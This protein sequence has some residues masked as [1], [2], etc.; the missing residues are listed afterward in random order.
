MKLWIMLCLLGLGSGLASQAM[1]LLLPAD[2]GIPFQLQDLEGRGHSSFDPDSSGPDMLEAR[3]GLAR[4]GPWL[5]GGFHLRLRPWLKAEAWVSGTGVD[6]GEHL[7]GTHT[8]RGGWTGRVTRGSMTM[9][10]PGFSLELGRRTLSHGMDMITELGWS[11]DVPPVDML[12]YQLA[13]KSRRLSL[14]VMTAQLA[15]EASTSLK[16]WYVSHRLTWRPGDDPRN[17]I[18]VGDHA[19]FAGEGR[20]FE[21]HYLSPFTP[22]FLENFEG[23]SEVDHA[24]T[25]D[26]DNSSLFLAWNW[27]LAPG[28]PFELRSYGELLV[29]EFQLDSDDRELL[30]DVLGLTLGVERPLQLPGTERASLQVEASWLSPWLYIHRGSGTSFLEKGHVIGNVEGGDARELHLRLRAS[31]SGEQRFLL[32]WSL[33]EK[34]SLPIDA[35]WNAEATQGQA[36]PTSPVSW[37]WSLDAAWQFRLGEAA[38]LGAALGWRQLDESLQFRLN[39]L[40][41]RQLLKAVVAVP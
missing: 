23:Y 41:S 24:E 38:L 9:D 20:G 17:R 4:G 8:T 5:E 33:L 30:D 40:L 10:L 39:L 16:R 32:G 1:P 13:T 29:D 37:S 25:V 3:L 18:L 31:T 7:L 27:W 28:S 12:R 11:R 26:D 34:G 19:I 35:A 36:W 2:P 22:Y 14:D 21:L 6:E 15:S